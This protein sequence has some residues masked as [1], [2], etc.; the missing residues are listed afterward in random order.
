VYYQTKSYGESGSITLS[1]FSAV[2]IR[3]YFCGECGFAEMYVPL[4]SNIEKIKS[5][6]EPVN[7]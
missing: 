3:H 4:D 5:K 2:L 7:K 6:C 1:T